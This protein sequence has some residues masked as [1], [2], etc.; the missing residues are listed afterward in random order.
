M[1]LALTAG[2]WLLGNWRVALPLL[3]LLVVSAWGGWQYLG[4]LEAENALADQ[5]L[6]TAVDANATWVELEAKRAAFE[7]S[8][9]EG[10]ERLK[11]EVAAIHAA[12]AAFQSKVKA[13]ANSNRPLD[14][15]ELDA[16]GL[17]VRRPGG[18]KAGGGA[19][20]PPVAPPP[21]R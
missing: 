12:N 7:S 9:L 6:Q 18:D 17:L 1:G 13:N 11:G 8:V 3:A 4:R 14:P 20:R 5:K 21:V 10:I 19:V 15:V 16:L 2:K